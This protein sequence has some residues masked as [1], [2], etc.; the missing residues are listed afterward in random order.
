ML[1]ERSPLHKVSGFCRA[2]RCLN[3]AVLNAPAELSGGTQF[4]PGR[5]KCR[6]DRNIG[7]GDI[8]HSI[9]SKHRTFHGVV[10]GLLQH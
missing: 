8:R 9:E 10:R 4:N 1:L 3:R 5:Q 6:P 7:R 2:R